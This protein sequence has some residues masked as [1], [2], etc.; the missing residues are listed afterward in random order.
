MKNSLDNFKN[1]YYYGSVFHG[2]PHKYKP[3]RSARAGG[4]FIGLLHFLRSANPNKSKSVSRAL[5]VKFLA[6]EPNLKNTRIKLQ[7]ELYHLRE[8]MVWRRDTSS[9]KDL[10]TG[11]KILMGF[12]DYYHPWCF[13]LAYQLNRYLSD[14]RD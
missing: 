4:F 7:N 13:G 2:G 12:Q 9:S 10:N 8:D 3:L 6:T 11:L 1:I 5:E 14:R